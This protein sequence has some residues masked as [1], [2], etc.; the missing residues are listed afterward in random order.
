MN[1]TPKCPYCGDRMEIHIRSYATE[2]ELFSAWYQ[3]VTC[4]SASP[5]IDFIGNMSQTTI[6]KRLQAMSSRRVEPKNRVLTL[7]EVRESNAVWLESSNG[8][9]TSPPIPVL[10]YGEATDDCNS[11]MPCIALVDANAN[12]VDYLVS[13]YNHNWRCWLRKPTEA[14]RRGT[15]WEN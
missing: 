8:R 9:L 14:E 12:M 3:C 10:V 5:R 11:N 2:Q 1:N 15:L 6:E 7:E 13:D 4:E